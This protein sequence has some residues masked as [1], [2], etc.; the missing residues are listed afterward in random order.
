MESHGTRQADDIYEFELHDIAGSSSHTTP[1]MNRLRRGPSLR[2][3][4]VS[5]APDWIITFALRWILYYISHQVTGFKRHFSL[6]DLSLQHPYAVHQRVGNQ[7]LFLLG[8]MLPLSAQIVVNLLVTRSWW[9]F[10]H[11]SL[12]LFLSL[13][14]TGVITQLVKIT[15][16]RPRPDF[17]SRCEPMSGSEDPPWGLSTADI[18]TQTTKHIL[19]D[20]W[21]SFPS[22][23]FQLGLFDSKWP[24]RDWASSAF[25]LAGKLRLFDARGHTYKVWLLLVPLGIASWIALSRTMD[26]RHHWEDVLTGSALGLSVA[27]FSYRQYYPHLTSKMAHI[28]FTTRFLQVEHDIEEFATEFMDGDADNEENVGLIDGNR[29][30]QGAMPEQSR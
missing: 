17:I 2:Q 28:P 15:V 25:Y 14:L 30:P 6:A 22:G 10:H 19:E 23:T 8:S 18:C 20:G 29:K 3:I 21:R 5:Y 4:V 27:F 13:T 1:I 9:D 16:G 12:G 26:Y 7:A 11:S 24:L